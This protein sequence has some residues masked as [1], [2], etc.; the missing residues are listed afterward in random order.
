MS[1]VQ[2]EWNT[3]CRGK[4]QR[5][6]APFMVRGKVGRRGA[7]SLCKIIIARD[8]VVLTGCA[9]N[10][11]GTTITTSKGGHFHEVIGL[12]L[13]YAAACKTKVTKVLKVAS[14]PSSTRSFSFNL[15][16]SIWTEFLP[17][18]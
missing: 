17:V 6:N 10:V 4:L 7:N 2:A 9:G 18:R 15:L 5:V 16:R 14:S 12:L 1:H 8:E 3:N 11:F 13:I